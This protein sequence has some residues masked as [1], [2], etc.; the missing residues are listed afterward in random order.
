MRSQEKSSPINHSDRELRFNSRELPLFIF[1]L[2]V[3]TLVERLY[4]TAYLPLCLHT[5]CSPLYHLQRSC[6]DR[7]QRKLRQRPEAA[8]RPGLHRPHPQIHHRT[9]LLLPS[10]RL[11]SRF[12][13]SPP[14]RQNPG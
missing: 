3:I 6:P 10:R 13:N 9:S 11:P 12:F 7:S 4:E 5:Y 8:H 14:P 2:V 1:A